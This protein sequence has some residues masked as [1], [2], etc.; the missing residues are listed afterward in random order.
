MCWWQ[1]EKWEHRS[2][3]ILHIQYC[4]CNHSIPCQQWD[5][6]KCA[7]WQEKCVCVCVCV[8]VI[9]SW[10]C[11][12][13]ST[14]GPGHVNKPW[15]AENSERLRETSKIEE[16]FEGKRRR[17]EERRKE[18]SIIIWTAQVNRNTKDNIASSRTSFNCSVYIKLEESYTVI[19]QLHFTL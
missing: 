15:A 19:L 9:R 12:V 1:R 17:K 7:F 5:Y 14:S 2:I 10:V 8:C 6:R 11:S 13:E 3:H 16:R 4:I 18:G